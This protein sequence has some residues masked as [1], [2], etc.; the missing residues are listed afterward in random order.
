MNFNRFISEV[1]EDIQDFIKI[2]FEIFYRL[3]NYKLYYN[4]LINGKIKKILL[5]KDEKFYISILL[6]SLFGDS[7]VKKLF[8]KSLL[9]YE[10]VLNNFNIS[11][12]KF[13]YLNEIEYDRIYNDYFIEYL[14]AMKS[15]YINLNSSNINLYQII[16]SL[17]NYEIIDDIFRD[18]NIIIDKTPLKYHRAF[19]CLQELLINDYK[20]IDIDFL[21][22][23][24]DKPFDEFETDNE[25]D[26]YRYEEKDEN[27]YLL[28]EM[29]KILDNPKMLYP[30][31]FKHGYIIEKEINSYSRLMKKEFTKL[32]ASLNEKKSVLLI[33]QSNISKNILINCLSSYVNDYNIYNFKKKILFNLNITSFL[34]NEKNLDEIK[35][36]LEEMLNAKNFIFYI[37]DIHD[38]LG[39]KAS[40]KSNVI[41]IF[42]N[43]ILKQ[44]IQVVGST[45]NSEYYNSINVR[46][47][48]GNM[49]DKIEINEYKN[50]FEILLNYINDKELKENILFNY[51]QKLKEYYINIIIQIINFSNLNLDAGILII[52]E[53]FNN[54]KLLN[55]GYLKFDDLKI[56]LIDNKHISGNL[57]EKYIKQLQQIASINHT[58]EKSFG[59]IL[60][61]P[62]N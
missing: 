58:E 23:K 61:F 50:K 33:T 13:N 1:P 52:D 32:T 29:N 18:L 48:Y 42:K 12:F 27:F 7:N 31:L 43:L 16:Y 26:D 28:Q 21:Y 10:D 55:S 35:M 24:N 37:E 22:K 62:G 47:S 34:D 17:N 3:E 41:Q 57:K 54:A 14:N 5:N 15:D 6:S 11:E 19:L 4:K 51:N 2:L 45:T 25:E 53:A 46:N 38:I 20:I 36:F 9:Y 49:F 60:K 59:K 44:K 39:K 56:T 30:L 40:Y 8:N